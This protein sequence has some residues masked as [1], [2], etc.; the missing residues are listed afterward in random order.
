MG[1]FQ[2]PHVSFARGVQ[3]SIISGTFLFPGFSLNATSRGESTPSKSPLCPT[4]KWGGPRESKILSIYSRA[5]QRTCPP[6][7]LCWPKRRQKGFKGPRCF[8]LVGVVD[9]GSL[10]K[11]SFFVKEVILLAA[12]SGKILGGMERRGIFF[13]SIEPITFLNCWLVWVLCIHVARPDSCG[14]FHKKVVSFPEDEKAL[15]IQSDLS[16]MVK[17]PFQRVTVSDLQLGDE[18]GTLNHLGS[19]FSLPLGGATLPVDSFN[20]GPA[21]N[22]PQNGTKKFQRLGRSYMGDF[23]HINWCFQCQISQASEC[24]QEASCDLV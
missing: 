23:Y 4:G 1:D 2:V 24:P 18:K 10:C 20:K 16:G 6:Q 22:L 5:S 17:W 11:V 9:E 15:V 21:F 3:G 19:S 13:N 12:S 7:H 8:F 14:C